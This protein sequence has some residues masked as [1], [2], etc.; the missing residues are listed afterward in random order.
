ME[1]RRLPPKKST[2]GARLTASTGRASPR[3]VGCQNCNSLKLSECI[4][5]QI[6][7]VASTSKIE[8]YSNKVP[9]RNSHL[10]PNLK[11][12]ARLNTGRTASDKVESVA[13]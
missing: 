9:L 12:Q 4:C 8:S 3:T 10:N 13:L 1:G 2:L 7:S 5:V 11:D 6:K